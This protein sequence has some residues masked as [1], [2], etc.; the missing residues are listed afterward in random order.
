MSHTDSKDNMDFGALP[1]QVFS[2]V[3]C[4]EFTEKTIIKMYNGDP[5]LIQ[6]AVWGPKYRIQGDSGDGTVPL[7]SAIHDGGSVYYI[8]GVKHSSLLSDANASAAIASFLAGTVPIG[9]SQVADSNCS[10]S[11]KLLTFSSNVK[12]TITNHTTGQILQPRQDYGVIQT[13]NDMHIF[14]PQS[15]LANYEVNVQDETAGDTAEN[16]SVQ[17]I[18]SAA[19]TTT[20]YN[21]NGLDIGTANLKMSFPADDPNSQNLSSVNN[22]TGEVSSVPPSNQQDGSYGD[23]ETADPT[24]T[25]TSTTTNTEPVNTYTPP[26]NTYTPSTTQEQTSPDNQ[27][28]DSNNNSSTGANQTDTDTNENNTGSLKMPTGDNGNADSSAAAD[29]DA[30]TGQNVPAQPESPVATSSPAAP[31]INVTVNLPS[32]L[33]SPDNSNT[34]NNIESGAD[35]KTGN[36]TN[37]P[38]SPKNQSNQ[39]QSFSGQ[40]AT[41]QTQVLSSGNQLI[42]TIKE[43]AQLIINM[44]F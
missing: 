20:T 33:G 24:A 5:N 39:N 1:Y 6:R 23:G 40:D 22:T 9:L 18:N 30:N 44:I 8:S 35:I 14:I 29:A 12:V 32:S 34:P 13:G 16:V 37:N 11:G 36:P 28:S 19:A 42:N 17:N 4:G 38:N 7:V 27:A 3:G 10:V 15:Q 41:G 25:T 26:A 2:L 43:L 21:Y 31:N